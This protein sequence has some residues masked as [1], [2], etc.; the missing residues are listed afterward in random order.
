MSYH[1]LTPQ[2]LDDLR[3]EMR[4]AGEW[5]KR[6]L[7]ARRFRAHEIGL[8]EARYI[9]QTEYEAPSGSMRPPGEY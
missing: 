9:S 6:Q 7:K 5:A 3:A 4:A 8:A 2:E 1:R